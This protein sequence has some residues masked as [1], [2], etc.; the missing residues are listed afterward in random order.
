MVDQMLSRIFTFT[1]NG[2]DWILKKINGVEVRLVSHWRISGSP[3]LALLSAPQNLNCLRNIRNRH[4]NNSFSYC[5]IAAWHFKDGP[6]LHGNASWRLHTST[7]K[8]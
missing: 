1:S 5:F 8:Y 6:N 4:D 3:Y 2:S 7:D